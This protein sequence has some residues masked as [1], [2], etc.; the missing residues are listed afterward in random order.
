[1]NTIYPLHYTVCVQTIFRNNIVSVCKE[2]SPLIL[3]GGHTI[4]FCENLHL[5]L[6][7]NKFYQT[8]GHLNFER[9]IYLS[10]SLK[11]IIYIFI[12]TANGF[13][14]GGSGTTIRHNTQTTHITQ[15]NTTIERNTVYKNT[16]RM[17]T[18]HRMK[19]QQL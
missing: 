13:S 2:N 16:C 4:F 6:K 18:L 8:N 9:P 1:V 19:I 10:S 15:N 3:S 12:L 5:F 14:P 11:H 17:N 7:Y